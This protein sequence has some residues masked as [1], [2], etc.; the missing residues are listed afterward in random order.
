MLNIL[1]K[2]VFYIIN[3]VFTVITAPLF[4]AVNALFPDITR[5]FASVANFL[6]IALTHVNFVCHMLFIPFTCFNLFFVYFF[7]KY[8]ILITVKAV[9]FIIK[10][11]D[12]LKP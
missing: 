6:D 4:V 3:K 9:K 8:T 1:V 2:A 11:Y 7:I 10:V 12:K 5:H